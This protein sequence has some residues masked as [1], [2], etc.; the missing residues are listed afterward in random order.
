MSE[1]RTLVLRSWPPCLQT[2]SIVLPQWDMCLLLLF[3]L[4]NSHQGSSHAHQMRFYSALGSDCN[5]DRL[6]SRAS[7]A[8][9]LRC[10][11]G[12][13]L[14]RQCFS[15]NKVSKVSNNSC[16]GP[17]SITCRILSVSPTL[18]KAPNLRTR[19]SKT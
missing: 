17:P 9:I 1:D 7:P 19:E 6:A 15:P 3:P 14:C 8:E 4:V 12:C 5:K 10:F 2:G 13:L 18:F 16:G 11:G